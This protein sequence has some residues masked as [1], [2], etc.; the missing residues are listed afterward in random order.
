MNKQITYNNMIVSLFWPVVKACF[1]PSRVDFF[2]RSKHTQGKS[3]PFKKE[4]KKEKVLTDEHR[5]TNKEIEN[6]EAKEKE[7][8]KS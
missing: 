2:C 6:E 7:H 5:H 4:G 3:S 8:C 1:Y